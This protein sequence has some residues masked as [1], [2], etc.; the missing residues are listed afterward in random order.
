MSTATPCPLRLTS[1]EYNAIRKCEAVVIREY[2]T[3]SGERF[4]NP[5]AWGDA[6]EMQDQAAIPG[7]FVV[8]VGLRIVAQKCLP[9]ADLLGV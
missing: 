5:V 3:D 1:D 7:L 9:V 4:A 2:E 6:D 8:P